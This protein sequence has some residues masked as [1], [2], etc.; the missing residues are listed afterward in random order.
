MPTI[1]ASLT[2]LVGKNG[3]L[4]AGNCPN[5]GIPLVDLFSAPASPGTL[6]L[7]KRTLARRGRELRQRGIPYVVMLV[8]SAHFVC[9]DDLPDD[10]RGKLRSPVPAFLATARALDNVT[11]IDLLEPLLHAKGDLAVYRKT[12][13]HW[14]EYGAYVAYRHA[15]AALRRLVPITEIT[16]ADVTFGMRRG[17]GDLSV[18]MWPEGSAEYF[19]VARID[20]EHHARLVHSNWVVA[21][22]RLLELESHSAGPTSAIIFHDSYMRAQTDFLSRTFGNTLLAGV[23]SRVFLDAV[24]AWRPDIVISEMADHRLFSKPQDHEP[25]TFADEFECD[26]SSPAGKTAADAMILLRQMKLTEAAEAIAGI[27]NEPGFGGF[28]ARVAAQI[29][30]GRH[31]FARAVAMARLALATQRDHPSYLWMAAFAEAYDKNPEAAVTLATWAVS[32]D[33]TNAAWPSLLA[34]LL[35]GLQRWDDAALLLENI[36]PRLDDSPDLWGSLAIVRK[37]RGDETG[38][39]EAEAVVGSFVDE[40]PGAEAGVALSA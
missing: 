8:P 22:N 2:A 9:A 18:R 13:T 34:S 15:C 40:L 26:C 1:A 33:S 38:A 37:A 7:W 30:V 36:V 35:I 6:R 21:R 31:E 16:D 29:L 39:A 24:D 3:Q 19:P 5:G 11:V 25:W 28:H 4:F 10:L 23:T 12:D 20:G 32:V 17:Y 14:T 27:E